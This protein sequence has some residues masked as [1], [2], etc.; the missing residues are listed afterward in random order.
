[1][2][3]VLS[4]DLGITTGYAVFTYPDQVLQA[5]GCLEDRDYELAL[6]ELRDYYRVSYSV[7]ERPVVIR[8]KLGDRLQKVIASTEREL[9]RQV[10]MV[11]P[12]RWKNTPYLKADLPPGGRKSPHEKDAIR[13]GLWYMGT[14]LHP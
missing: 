12:H 1:M 8:G 14:Q 7:A 9:M 4:L 5:F 2:K 10:E 6:K 11:D 3:H 13:L